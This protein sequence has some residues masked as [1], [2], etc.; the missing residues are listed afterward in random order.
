MTRS[1]MTR[2]TRSP[3]GRSEVDQRLLAGG[4]DGGAIAEPLDGMGEKTTLDG[5]VVDDEDGA[6]HQAGDDRRGGL[7]GS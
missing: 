6:G 1:R 5:V 4:G 7:T 3:V 2:E